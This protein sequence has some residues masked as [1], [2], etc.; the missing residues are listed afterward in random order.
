M[1]DL[2]YLIAKQLEA[3]FLLRSEGGLG[4][5]RLSFVIQTSLS[6]TYGSRFFS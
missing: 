5:V 2:I 6:G 1:H 3:D 4:E